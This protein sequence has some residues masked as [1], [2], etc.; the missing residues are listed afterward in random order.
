MTLQSHPAP[1]GSEH[2]AAAAD[3]NQ[4]LE[5]MA[6]RA[7]EIPTEEFEA[8]VDEAMDHVRPWPRST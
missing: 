7:L 5:R 1:S 4:V 8:V 3:L 6:D 2:D